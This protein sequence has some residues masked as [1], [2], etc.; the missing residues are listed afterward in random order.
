M[1]KTETPAQDHATLDQYPTVELVNAL[2]E[3]K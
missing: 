1:L 2:E 3:E